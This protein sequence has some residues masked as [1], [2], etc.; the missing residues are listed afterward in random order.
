MIDPVLSIHSFKAS[1]RHSESFPRHPQPSK[2]IQSWPKG[3][4]GAP[5][6]RPGLGQLRRC[7]RVAPRGGLRLAARAGAAQRSGPA[8]RC[9]K[10]GFYPR[11]KGISVREVAIE[12]IRM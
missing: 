1:D 3:A 7:L 10:R 11:N 9:R 4:F 12:P 8:L 2:I 5:L 6:G